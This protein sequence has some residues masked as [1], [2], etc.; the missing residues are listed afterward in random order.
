M[1]ID[2]SFINDEIINDPLDQ[3]I[4]NFQKQ[5]T[6]QANYANVQ[7]NILNSLKNKIDVP[8]FPDD[9]NL[10]PVSDTT[11]KV[12]FPQ[13]ANKSKDRPPDILDI[14]DSDSDNDDENTNIMPNNDKPQRKVTFSNEIVD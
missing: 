5:T 10:N 14:L 13:N 1:E 4:Q 7:D 2:D 8:K 3:S 11:V 9:V 12:N 6:Q